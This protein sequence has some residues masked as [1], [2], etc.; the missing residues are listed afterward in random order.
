MDNVDGDYSEKTKYYVR[1][2]GRNGEIVGLCMWLWEKKG[3][4]VG[5]VGGAVVLGG[6]VGVGI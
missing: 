4:R 6:I 5:V 1:G 2:Y 3:N